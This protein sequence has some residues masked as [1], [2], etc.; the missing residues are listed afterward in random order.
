MRKLISNKHEITIQEIIDAIN[1]KERIII[2]YRSQNK[3]DGIPRFLRYKMIN[4]QYV[5][6]FESPFI[7]EK[8]VYDCVSYNL[9]PGIKTSLLNAMSARDIYV[10]TY[11]EGN[12]LFK[13]QP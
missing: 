7:A 6:G 4:G 13:V 5:I 11:E 3:K 2:Y 9:E 8:P 1:N 10:I 12:K